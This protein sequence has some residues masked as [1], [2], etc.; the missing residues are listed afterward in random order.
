MIKR[1]FI[2]PVS[3]SQS[4]LIIPT[5]RITPWHRVRV[6]WCDLCID[7]CRVGRGHCKRKRVKLMGPKY[8]SPGM[9]PWGGINWDHLCCMCSVLIPEET[10]KEDRR[11]IICLCWKVRPQSAGIIQV[12]LAAWQ[13]RPQSATSASSVIRTFRCNP[14][15][16]T[17]PLCLSYFFDETEKVPLS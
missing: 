13:N 1:T 4:R 2:L 6:L 8:C 12:R 3:L 11:L 9:S 17:T 7:N 16:I 14:T 5:E 15:H 10:K